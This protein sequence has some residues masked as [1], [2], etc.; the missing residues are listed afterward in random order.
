MSDTCLDRKKKHAERDSSN[1]QN[2][3]HQTRPRQLRFI[4][5]V[6][7]PFLFTQESF[8]L[9]ISFQQ[10]WNRPP[11]HNQRQTRKSLKVRSKG[12]KQSEET[13]ASQM[14]DGNRSMN[15]RVLKW[16]WI[17]ESVKYCSSCKRSLE[18]HN[19][20]TSVLRM[21]P[22]QVHFFWFM[23]LIYSLRNKLFRL[24]RFSRAGTIHPCT[25]G[26]SRGGV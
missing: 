22:A 7:P 19:I 13:V 10:S 5:F 24:F 23:Y 8:V 15:Y 3:L 25:T 1:R 20:P 2:R 17:P 4:S 9:S 6:F 21:L 12:A 16:N 14:Q 18:C 26:I 11:L